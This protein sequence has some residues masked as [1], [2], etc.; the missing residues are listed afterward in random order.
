[1]FNN[2]TER[3][4]ISNTDVPT[5]VLIICSK[6]CDDNAVLLVWLKHCTKPDLTRLCNNYSV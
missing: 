6:H 3:Y 1:M 4:T 5:L 2:K